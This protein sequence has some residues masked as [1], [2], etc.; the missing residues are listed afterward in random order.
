MPHGGEKDWFLLVRDDPSGRR[1][2]WQRGRDLD[3]KIVYSA[4][5]MR[6][7]ELCA[8]R[9]GDDCYLKISIG[10]Q[11]T[12]EML[13]SLLEAIGRA[14]APEVFYDDNQETDQETGQFV[15][16]SSCA[17]KP[18]SP[19]LCTECLIRRDRWLASR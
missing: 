8:G 6:S 4:H 14:R 5:K 10:D 12:Q 17:A 9:E 13:C 18:G 15:E 19:I 3:G 11:V 2:L 16:C 7:V 1:G